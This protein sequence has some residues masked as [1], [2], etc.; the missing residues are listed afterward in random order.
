[1]YWEL[2]RGSKPTT[3]SNFSSDNTRNK[4]TTVRDS[5]PLTNPS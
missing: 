4:N 5:R 1:M 2:Q 3:N